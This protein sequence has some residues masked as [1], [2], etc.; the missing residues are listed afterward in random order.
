[1]IFQNNYPRNEY[2]SLIR[3]EPL[4]WLYLLLF[5]TPIITSWGLHNRESQKARSLYISL[6]W[7]SVFFLL[8]AEKKRRSEGIAKM[9]QG[10]TLDI[11][12]QNVISFVSS[13][14]RC[15]LFS[16][17]R[18]VPF[19]CFPWIV[20]RLYISRETWSR[21]LL[22]HPLTATVMSLRLKTPEAFRLNN[23]QCFH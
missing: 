23:D 7:K 2:K 9:S 10:W 5:S 16:V 21:P 15:P 8:R 20:K 6:R 18:E 13:C 14:E 19:F 22:Y 12:F 1:V 11:K 3:R 4:F 17:K